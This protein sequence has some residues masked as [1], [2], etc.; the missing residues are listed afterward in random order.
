MTAPLLMAATDP[1]VPTG[2]NTALEC[3]ISVRGLIGVLPL[4]L[5]VWP[6]CP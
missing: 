5:V 1:V 4:P 3:L 2:S 6:T